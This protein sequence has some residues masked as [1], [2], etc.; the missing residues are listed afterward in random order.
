M[1]PVLKQNSALRNLVN[2]H[3]MEYNGVDNYKVKK[4][5][6]SGRG[7]IT[8]NCLNMPSGSR[9]TLKDMEE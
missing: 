5:K 8:K 3:N 7:E 4:T 1:F 2:K 9:L 6:S